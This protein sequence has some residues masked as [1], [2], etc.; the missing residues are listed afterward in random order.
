MLTMVVR[1]FGIPELRKKLLFTLGVI[2]LFRFGQILPSPGVD[3]VAVQRCLGGARGGLVDMVQL[4]SGGAMLKL[5]VFALGVMPYITAS[6]IMQ[7]M[8][9]LIRA[10]KRC[11]RRGRTARR[12]SRSTPGT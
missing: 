6:I 12:R 2:V 10:S 1:A 4:F 11:A 9:V 3:T 5:S 8:A 7:L